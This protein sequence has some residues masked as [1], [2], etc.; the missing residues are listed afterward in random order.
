MSILTDRLFVSLLLVSFWRR[1]GTRPG[2][3]LYGDRST[4][5]FFSSEMEAEKDFS[6]FS[7]T[8]F[9][10]S[11]RF[12]PRFCSCIRSASRRIYSTTAYVWWE[13]MASYINDAIS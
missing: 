9:S 10:L 11:P 6:A 4:N 12:I 13:N 1:I 7:A 5:R 8:C 2:K 3:T